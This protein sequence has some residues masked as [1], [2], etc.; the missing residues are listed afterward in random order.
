MSKVLD[1]DYQ[2]NIENGEVLFHMS[3]CGG[4]HRNL[5]PEIEIFGTLAE[6]LVLETKFGN[7]IPPNITPDI[8]TG[9]GAWSDADFVNALILGISPDGIH[10]YPSFPYTSYTQLTLEDILDIKAFLFDLDPVN[11]KAKD[12]ELRFPFNIR[13][14]N[15]FWKALFFKPEDFRYDPSQSVE[16]NRGAYLVN[17]VG[18]CG[19]CHTPRNLF[20]AEKT[21]QRF[22]GAPPLKEGEKS[23]PRI[24]GVDQNTIINGL[25]EWAGAINESSSMYL[26]TQAYSQYATFSDIEAIVTYLSSLD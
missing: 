24:A 7:F 8:Q 12:H 3:G 5:N 18:H 13:L 22:H 1:S 23:A 26:V 17:S 19:S 9:I 21:D 10:Y 11:H 2:P 25:D 15:Y 16:W 4:C 14:G 20:F 6:G